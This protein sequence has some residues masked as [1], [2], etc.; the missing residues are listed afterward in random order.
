MNMVRE[1]ISWGR[2]IWA[3]AAAALRMTVST[4]ARFSSRSVVQ[5]ICV[6]ATVT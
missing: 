5:A 1:N 2:T 3:P 6:A 4:V